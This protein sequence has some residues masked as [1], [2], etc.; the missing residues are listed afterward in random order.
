[1]PRWTSRWTH[2]T[3][4]TLDQ[5]LAECAECRRYAA[6]LQKLEAR[7]GPALESRW[8]AA[9]LSDGQ[10]ASIL[11]KILSHTRRTPMQTRISGSVRAL[12]LGTLA[13]L[14]IVAL[15]WGVRTLRPVSPAGGGG[16]QSVD[17]RADAVRPNR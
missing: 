4:A 11:G 7:L 17:S 6:R 14:L 1:M 12:A 9:P 16:T 5:H 3:Q 10:R 2:E 8:P 13:I 15:G